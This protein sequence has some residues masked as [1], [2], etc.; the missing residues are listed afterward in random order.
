MTHGVI[1]FYGRQRLD[2]ERCSACGS[3]VND[4]GKLRTVLLLDRDN[5]AFGTNGDNC[6]LKA[7][8]ICRVVQ[9]RGEP[10][11]HTVLCGKH[12][13]CHTPKF[14]TRVV[15]EISVLVDGVLPV[16]FEHP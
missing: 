6:L 7:F 2:K 1:E 9:N 13:S 8:L 4:A 16:F 10:F 5:V 15:T 11:F 14:R 12:L 3:I